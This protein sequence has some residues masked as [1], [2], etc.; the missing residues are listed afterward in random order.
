MKKTLISAI[1]FA[2]IQE[3][4]KKLKEKYEFD[5]LYLTREQLNSLEHSLGQR[6]GI[7]REDDVDNRYH[8]IEHEVFEKR[9]KD[10]VDSIKNNK[11][12]EELFSFKIALCKEDGK[13]YMIDGQSAIEGVNIISKDGNYASSLPE[14]F[15]CTYLGKLPLD[16]IDRLTLL[17]NSIAPRKRWAA[18]DVVAA[19]L[20]KQGGDALKAYYIIKDFQRE[21][22]CLE[23]MASYFCVHKYIKADT[24]PENFCLYEY[25]EHYT[26]FYREFLKT[27][28][29][30][31]V[32]NGIIDEKESIGSY[33]SR[34]KRVKN[35][36][37]GTLLLYTL[38]LC[39]YICKQHNLNVNVFLPIYYKRILDYF[40]N[41]QLPYMK[42]DDAMATTKNRFITF[43]DKIK[44]DSIV[45]KTFKNKIPATLYK[46]D[47]EDFMTKKYVEN[48]MK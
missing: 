16:E 21:T 41:E 10:V 40:N 28:G 27:A 18:S 30:I 26:E 38:D 6:C 17:M 43:A 1:E 8:I 23:T 7:S 44:L 13:L 14:Y 48:K 2:Q 39:V 12:T 5:I 45:G 33:F 22:G 47:Y 34:W 37:I 29:L 15:V 20:R 42:W 35:I 46:K 32:E 24:D 4:S 3:Q 11:W 25:Y 31:Y 9:V 19:K 36:Q